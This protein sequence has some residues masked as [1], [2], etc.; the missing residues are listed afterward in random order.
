MKSSQG[1][2]EFYLL[3]SKHALERQGSSD[4][5]KNRRFG[6]CHRP[7]LPTPNQ[8]HETFCGNQCKYPSP[9]LLVLCTLPPLPPHSPINLPLPTHPTMHECLQNS[10]CC[11]TSS[12]QPWWGPA[13]L[14]SDSSLGRRTTNTSSTVDP[15]M[16]WRRHLTGL[17]APPT[18][19]SNSQDK[20][21]RAPWRSI[22]L[23]PQTDWGWPLV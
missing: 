17:P 1:M 12:K 21:Q 19:K 8:D 13:P 3:I 10:S 18:N 15:E 5:S 16:H 2:K 9:T 6:M 23:Q 7:H 22:L 4:F 11:S 20:A 14:Q